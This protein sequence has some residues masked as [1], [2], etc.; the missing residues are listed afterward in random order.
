LGG[1]IAAE[2]QGVGV[3]AHGGDAERDMVFHGDAQ[4]CGAVAD[5]VAVD[6]AGEGFVPEFLFYGRT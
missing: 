6:A 5:I 3:F 2:A 4:F 1:E